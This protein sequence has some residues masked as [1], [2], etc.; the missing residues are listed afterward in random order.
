M[1]QQQDNHFIPVLTSEAGSCLTLQNWQEVG[2]ER[3]SY[4]LDA[5][6]IKPGY[7]LLSSLNKLASYTGWQGDIVLNALL[8]TANAEGIYTLRSS[9]DGS[10]V[11]LSNQDLFS[12]I[13]QLQPNW[14]ILPPGFVTYLN[15]Q[16]LAFPESIKVFISANESLPNS[17]LPVFGSYSS[18][19]I[20]LL[21]NPKGD[22]NNNY[23]FETD[24]PAQDAME[25][26]LYSA[27]GVIAILEPEKA[28]EHIKIDNQCCCPTCRQNFT[29]A[30]LHHL[31]I[32]TPLLAQRFLIQH[33]VYYA[34]TNI[35]A[36]LADLIC[37]KSNRFIYER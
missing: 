28:N 10:R 32:H 12:L 6:L 8:P 31:L 9:Y 2:I 13:K 4:W 17:H 18:S 26:N 7:N 24:K 25:G 14:V 1:T 16:Q 20:G 11:R 27:Q 34:K 23:W 35:S 19:D 22:N 30:Y 3:V 5:L 33:N 37:S 29:R 21:L 36:P 15:H